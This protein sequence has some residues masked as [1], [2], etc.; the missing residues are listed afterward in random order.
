MGGMHTWLWG[1]T[2]PTFMDA[3]MPLASLPAEIAGRNRMIRRM[4]IDSIRGDPAWKGGEYETQPPGLAS[5]LHALLFMVSSPLQWQKAA[6]TRE[7]ADRFLEE[8]MRARGTGADAND[9]LYAFEASSDYDPAPQLEAIVAP[10]LAVNSADDEVN[11]P[12]LGIME[13]NIARVRRGRYVLLP[14]SER[15]RGH[16]THSLPELWQ[17][18]LA[19]LLRQSEP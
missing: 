8:Q 16:G 6:P 9:M 15:T 1:E 13:R 17:E 2:W 3:L 7:A 19:E 14:V 11:P 18:H 10:L 5:A 4:V 12:E